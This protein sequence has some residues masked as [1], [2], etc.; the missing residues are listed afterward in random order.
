M[1]RD[2]Y[3]TH[4]QA[5]RTVIRTMVTLGAAMLLSYLILLFGV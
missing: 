1:I 5:I 2:I 4:Y 3:F